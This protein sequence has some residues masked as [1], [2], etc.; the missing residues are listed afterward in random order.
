MAKELVHTSSVLGSI[1][2]SS[3]LAMLLVALAPLAS[4]DFSRDHGLIAVT[5]T[6]GAG[7]SGVIA[8]K[9][10]INGSRM[11]HAN[12]TLTAIRSLQQDGIE[13]VELGA[14][15]AAADGAGEFS[16]HEGPF[17]LTT[18]SSP[19]LD[20]WWIFANM[21]GQN[22]TTDS[23]TFT[24]TPCASDGEEPTVEIPFFPGFTALALGSLGALGTAGYM[25]R[26]RS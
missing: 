13:V 17:T 9:F 15:E 5:D 7:A 20:N 3:L 4:A 8:C 14:W 6:E 18:E 26:R 23:D 11:T 16:F 22:H 2:G 12:G 19:G 10:W 1:L 25:I 24:Y 21:D